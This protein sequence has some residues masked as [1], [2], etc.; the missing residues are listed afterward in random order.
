MAALLADWMSWKFFYVFCNFFLFRNVCMWE[1]VCHNGSPVTA[2]TGWKRQNI[3][4]NKNPIFV[5]PVWLKNAVKWLKCTQSQY[6][7]KRAGNPPLTQQIWLSQL[8][9][10]STHSRLHIETRCSQQGSDEEFT[11]DKCK[12]KNRPN[13][14]NPL[15]VR[16]F[17]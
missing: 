2:K 7:M 9:I 3:N 15:L 8:G 10:H 6:D 16:H 11:C 17:C 13:N 12:T 4:A 5:C 1:R 14:S